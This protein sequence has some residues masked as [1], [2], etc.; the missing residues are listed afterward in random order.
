[1]LGHVLA[2]LTLKIDEICLVSFFVVTKQQGLF[3]CLKT[4]QGRIISYTQIFQVGKLFQRYL[5]DKVDDMLKD[6]NIQP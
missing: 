5:H 3:P 1:M 6:F 4:K 2:Q